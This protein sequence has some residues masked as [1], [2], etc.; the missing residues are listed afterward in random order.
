MGDHLIP[1]AHSSRRLADQDASLR[2]YGAQSI[3]TRETSENLILST[4]EGEAV[5]VFSDVLACNALIH[6][7]DAPLSIGSFRE[8]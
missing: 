2:T 4:D 6:F 1:L 8:T 7:I 5:I 3:S